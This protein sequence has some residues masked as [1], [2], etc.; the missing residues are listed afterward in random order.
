MIDLFAINREEISKDPDVK[1]SAVA[2]FWRVLFQSLK[3]AKSSSAVAEAVTAPILREIDQ[4]IGSE[5][6]ES[7]E[8]KRKE[9]MEENKKAQEEEMEVD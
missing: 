7:I 4:V 3:D 9:R 2:T 1:K 5:L 8:K 6:R